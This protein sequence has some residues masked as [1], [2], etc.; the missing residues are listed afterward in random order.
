MIIERGIAVGQQHPPD[1]VSTYRARLSH[2]DSRSL[3]SQEV[4]YTVT[5]SLSCL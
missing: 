1:S 3:S 2:D 4:L 5:Y